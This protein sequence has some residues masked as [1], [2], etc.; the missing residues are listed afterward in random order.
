MSIAEKPIRSMREQIC[1]TVR[2]EVFS[3]EL[4]NDQP[5][6][7]KPLAEVI[8]DE[9]RRTGDQRRPLLGHQSAPN[10][11]RVKTLSLTS[12][13]ASSR[14]LATMTSDSALKASR[15]RSTRLPKKL[16]S[17]ITGS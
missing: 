11:S 9:A 16:S 17:S 12:F 10:R 2:A 15:S 4:T 14:R 7:E 8:A 5:V 1:E 3:G 6:R 13:S